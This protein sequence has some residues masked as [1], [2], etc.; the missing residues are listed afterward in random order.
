MRYQRGKVESLDFQLER[1][2]GGQ[3]A[4]GRPPL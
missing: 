2:C 3:E 1:G 4:C